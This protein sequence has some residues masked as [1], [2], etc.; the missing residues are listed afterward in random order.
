VEK[1]KIMRNIIKISILTMVLVFS[2]GCFTDSNS[3]SDSFDVVEEV[4]LVDLTIEEP[5]AKVL[6]ADST[7]KAI[8]LVTMDAGGFDTDTLI[9]TFDAYPSWWDGA[10]AYYAINKEKNTGV[11]DLSGVSTISFQIQSDT[12]LPGELAYL[13]QWET[14]VMEGNEYTIPLSEFVA[15][16]LIDWKEITINL[17][18][19]D[20]PEITGQ[21]NRYN[22]T[23]TKFVADKGNEN[24]D[25]AFSIKW[26]GSAATDPNTGPL[27]ADENYQIRN[28]KFLDASGENVNIAAGVEAK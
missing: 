22:Y 14:G 24:V 1:I 8:E 6:F 4:V 25:N 16:D 2:F 20:I 18:D 28:I 3:N 7:L 23:A 5:G 17:T 13:I 15:T 19:G 11:F 10:L 26:Y 9:A 12:I 21:P 27:E